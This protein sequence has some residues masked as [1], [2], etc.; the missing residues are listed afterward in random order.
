MSQ[1]SNPILLEHAEDL[2]STA[3]E[4]FGDD[5]EFAVIINFSYGSSQEVKPSIAVYSNSP[6]CVTE[7]LLEKLH[8]KY[9]QIYNFYNFDSLPR[10]MKIEALGGCVLYEKNA[11]ALNKVKLTTY[12]EAGIVTP[13]DSYPWQD[14]QVIAKNKLFGC[15]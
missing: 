15:R 1:C 3:M 11:D 6:E 2:I 4:N 13:W 8:D 12:L 10:R 7:K 9:G 5:L 14:E